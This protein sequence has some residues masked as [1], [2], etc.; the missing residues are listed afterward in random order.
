MRRCLIIYTICGLVASTSAAL[1]ASCGPDAPPAP[2]V[3]HGFNCE[4]FYDNFDHPIGTT[5]DMG[6][7]WAPGFKWYLQGGQAYP[8]NP[9]DVAIQAPGTEI[10]G[11]RLIPDIDWTAANSATNFN[12]LW[13]MGSCAW[14]SVPDN[15]W[16]GQQNVVQGSM[17]MQVQMSSI[18]N[19]TGGYWWPAIWNLATGRLFES[20]AAHNPEID[21][22]EFLGGGRNIHDWLGASD[23]SPTP[24]GNANTIVYPT[25]KTYGVLILKPGDNGGVGTIRAYEGAAAGTETLD[26]S[27]NVTWA[28]G[29]LYSSTSEMPLCFLI[30]S[31]YNQAIVIR[32][33]RVW[34]VTPPGAGIGGRRFFP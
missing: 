31:G 17:Y 15:V 27:H 26:N 10:G 6:Q 2:A 9:A 13:N 25:P 3:A 1:S 21:F 30:T 20:T 8:L 4:V 16:V 5:V 18:S 24:Y 33:I 29:G 14:V 28:P 23:P 32:S 11:L 12:G 7:T 22:F 19:G 34:Q